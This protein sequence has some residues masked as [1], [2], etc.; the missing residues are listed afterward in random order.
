MDENSIVVRRDKGGEIRSVTR[1]V[2]LS[3]D[4]GTL[5][6]LPM[7]GTDGTLIPSAR[8]FTEMAASC[9]V[10]LKPNPSVFVDGRE[11]P[12]PHVDRDGKIWARAVAVGRTA[13]GTLFATNKV[14]IYDADLYNIQDLLAK[15]KQAQNAA[16][17]RILPFQGAKDNQLLGSPEQGKWVGYPLD[18]FTVLW[19]DCSCPQFISWYGEMVNRRKNAIRTA[20]THADRNAL[21]AHPALPAQRKFKTPT[22]VIPCKSWFSKDG[23]ILD[24]GKLEFLGDKMLAAGHEVEVEKEQ[25]IAIDGSS[26]ETCAVLKAEARADIA[27]P[28]DAETGD[29]PE[30][31]DETLAAPETAPAATVVQQEPA[32]EPEQQ[33]TARMELL[34]SVEQC[35]RARPNLFAAVCKKLELDPTNVGKADTATLAKIIERLSA[36]MKPTTTAPKAE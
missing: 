17:F 24:S 11:Y 32:A 36:P 21:A 5:V 30:V 23:N 7:G 31:V 26:P 20:Q 12:S 2:K 15:A 9:G 8:G 28:V 25:V 19:V 34:V 4:D 29:D 1:S 35:R 22:A 3:V 13:L 33:R 16:F 10:V 14:V 6:R 27:E 18:Q